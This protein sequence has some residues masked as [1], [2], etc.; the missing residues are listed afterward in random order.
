MDAREKQ[1]AGGPGPE[2]GLGRPFW[3]QVHPQGNHHG[4]GGQAESSQGVPRPQGRLGLAAALPPSAGPGGRGPPGSGRPQPAVMLVGHL[5][6]RDLAS[7]RRLAAYNKRIQPPSPQNPPVGAKRF[8]IHR[9]LDPHRP[10]IP[11]RARTTSDRTWPIAR[12]NHTFLKK[13]FLTERTEVRTEV[14]EP[15]TVSAW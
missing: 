1:K 5:Q 15:N 14:T 11:K 9:E 4:R 2:L 3:W 12:S 13:S 7:G 6:P 10:V 8:L